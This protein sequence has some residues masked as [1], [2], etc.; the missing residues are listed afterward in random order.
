MLSAP[1]MVPASASSR[2]RTSKSRALPEA[3]SDRSSDN[4]TVGTKMTG[5]N[6]GLGDHKT[7]VVCALSL[8]TSQPSGAAVTPLCSSLGPAYTAPLPHPRYPHILLG[9]LHSWC[10]QQ[11]LCDR[12]AGMQ[13]AAS[14]L[15]PRV[16]P[17]RPEIEAKCGTW[18]APAEPQEHLLVTTLI[19]VH[20]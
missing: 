3:R 16:Q 6:Q 18:L 11:Q 9:Y 19:P 14:P 12:D 10:Q 2:D 20:S 8:G 1:G 13:P 7:P 17:G 5:K 4:E 15:P